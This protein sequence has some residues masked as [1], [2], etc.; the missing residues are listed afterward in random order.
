[1]ERNNEEAAEVK[2]TGEHLDIS[3]KTKKELRK[4][5]EVSKRPRMVAF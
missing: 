4:N 3:D 2:G 5:H 1:M